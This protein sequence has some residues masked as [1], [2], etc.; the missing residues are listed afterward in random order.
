MSECKG[1]CTRESWCS[2]LAERIRYSGERIIRGFYA[3]QTVDLT[4]DGPTLEPKTIGIAY[5]E[6]AKDRGLMLNFCPF[7][8]TPIDWGFKGE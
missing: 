6:S 3:I 7:C 2:A 4:S 1:M 8:G 5:R